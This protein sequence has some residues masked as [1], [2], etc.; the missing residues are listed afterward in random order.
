MQEKKNV[1]LMSRKKL[2]KHRLHNQMHQSNKERYRSGH[3]GTV[4]KSVVR[5]RTVGSNPTLSAKQLFSPD[6]IG[7]DKR[8]RIRLDPP[9]FLL[10]GYTHSWWGSYRYFV[11]DISSVGQSSRLITGLSG[12]QLPDVPPRDRAHS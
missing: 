9:N 1:P 10:A 2:R 5:Q 12:V 6:T 7:K 11:W 4:L 8:Q 3:N